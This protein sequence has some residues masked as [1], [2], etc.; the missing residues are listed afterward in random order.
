MYKDKVWQG[1]VSRRAR[2]ESHWP[3]ASAPKNI[4]TFIASYLDRGQNLKQAGLWETLDACTVAYAH[5][6]LFGSMDQE[7]DHG[8]S[9]RRAAIPLH[10]AIRSAR[11]EGASMGA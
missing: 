9:F 11:T 7:A 1:D 2:A 10:E 8:E 5:N 6:F 4:T 3:Q